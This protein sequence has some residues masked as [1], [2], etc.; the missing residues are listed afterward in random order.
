MALPNEE[1]AKA[2]EARGKAT[3]AAISVMPSIGCASET[4]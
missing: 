4:S 3:E 2:F 1:N